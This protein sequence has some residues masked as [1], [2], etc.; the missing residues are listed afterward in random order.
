MLRH[1]GSC[2]SNDTR[3]VFGSSQ[4]PQTYD[5]L[6]ELDK[7]YIQ[8]MNLSSPF[9]QTTTSNEC[10]ERTVS[11]F[12]TNFDEGTTTYRINVGTSMMGNSLFLEIAYFV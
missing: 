12:G 7:K 3:V 2:Q 5:R 6:W 8:E 1:F 10:Y 11:G 9:H 4:A